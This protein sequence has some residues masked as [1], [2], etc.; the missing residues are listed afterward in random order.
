MQAIR[1]VTI[2]PP[3]RTRSRTVGSL[4]EGKLAD[5]AFW[6]R[7]S[8]TSPRPILCASPRCA[9]QRPS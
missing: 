2:A 9:W 4:E 8:W 7:T 6:T 1:A 3:T 5:F